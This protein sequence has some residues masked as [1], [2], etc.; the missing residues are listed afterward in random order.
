M[1]RDTTPDVLVS[2]TSIR[3]AGAP[4]ESTL[5]ILAALATDATTRPDLISL[6]LGHIVAWTGPSGARQTEHFPNEYADIVAVL[7]ACRAHAIAPELG[8]MDLGFVNNAVT[9]REDGILVDDD[10]FLLEL[11]SPRWGAGRQTAPS[12]AVVYDALAEALSDQFPAA[13]WAA[14]GTGIPNWDIV[15][16]AIE[17][18][19]HI[20]VGFEDNLEAPSG[21]LASSNGEQVAWA[22]ALARHQGREPA[23]PAQARAI[24]GLD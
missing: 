20:R 10:W 11:D 24:I 14:H 19:A 21:A 5:E 13:R 17:R 3:P 18:G 1:I 8:V 22:A 7:A 2:I 12:T 15:T 9:L 16:R 23:T 4:V 6:N